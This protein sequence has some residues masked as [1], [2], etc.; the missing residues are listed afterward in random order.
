MVA[1][2]TIG[3]VLKE[4]RTDLGL[5][6]S[7]AEKLTN[8]P[9]LYIIALETGDYKA[10]PGD[11]YIKAYL[12]Q[13]AEKLELDADQIL[14][15][16]E[17]D[18]SM[19]VED[20]ED[21]QETYRFVKPS[22]RVEESEEEEEVDVPAWRHYVPIILLSAVALAIVG[23]VTAVVLLSRPQ[24]NDLED[25]SYTYKTSET[26]KSTE[27]KKTS[28]SKEKPVE[29]KPAPENQ[30]TVTGSGAQLNVKVDNA[31][32]PTKIVFTTAAGTVTTISLTNADW[33][34]VRTLSDAENTATA[35]LG[36]GLTNSVINLSNT[37]G[38]TMT[39]NGSNVDLSA[40]TVGSAVS[41]QLT[42]AYASTTE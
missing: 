42:V 40:L 13:Y 28:E 3:E 22:E 14:L 39:I 18:G 17:K 8:I 27:Q 30:L 37:Q 24:S 38:L 1:I 7:E 5:G 19:T 31:T 4:K 20:H 11:F 2:K 33:A 35:T 32:S 15:A 25:A 10:L 12:K 29:S 36:A 6:L 23:G 16:Y 41:V 34:T 26:V 9:K 21:I